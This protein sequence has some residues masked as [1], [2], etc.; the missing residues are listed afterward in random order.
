MWDRGVELASHKNF[1]VSTKVNVYLCDPQRP[2]QRG[3]NENTYGLLRQ[4]FPGKTN[5]SGY[6]QFDLDKLARQL[7]QRPRKILDFE[8]PA[9]KL[10]AGVAS[11]R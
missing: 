1:T 11:A 9:S 3:I 10:H 8:T 4:Y 2:W 6:S 7:N 5:L